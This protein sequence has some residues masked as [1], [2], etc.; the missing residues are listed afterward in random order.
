MAENKDPKKPQAPPAASAPETPAE[1]PAWLVKTKAV[2]ATMGKI[3]KAILNS[4]LIQG[5]KK[6]IK[7]FGLMGWMKVFTCIAVA[8]LTYTVY[9]TSPHWKLWKLPYLSSLES[10]ADHKF[11]YSA[12]SKVVRYDND[13]LLPQ[14]TVL[15][16]KI[17]VNIRAGKLS[18]R[19][20]MV[21][22]DLYVRTNNEEASV[23]IKQREK[24]LQD[25]L[26]RFCEGLQYDQ[27]ITEDGKQTWKNR[28]KRELNLILNTGKVKEIF[29]KTLLIKP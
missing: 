4:S 19:N 11:N 29:F 12:D 18:T 3:S 26:Q 20:P 16:N 9:K 7:S 1:P 17:V 5:P 24:Q 13:L 2:L 14:Y 22:F 27:I 25:H 28:M 8:L 21:A 15:I 6:T 10:V 23:E